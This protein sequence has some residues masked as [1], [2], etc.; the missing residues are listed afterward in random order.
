M[1]LLRVTPLNKRR[2]QLFTQNKRGY[3]SFWIFAVLFLISVF[4]PFIANDRP[5]LVSYK[6]EWLF[7]TFVDYL[8]SKF[9]GFLARTDYRDPVIAKEIAD[10]GWALWPPIRFASNTINLDLQEPA[11]GTSGLAGLHPAWGEKGAHRNRVLRR[12]RPAAA[13]RCLRPPRG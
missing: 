7:P 4:A 10:H 6:G 1:A 3:W 12:P 13:P 2:W 8:E 11:P 5:I 9:G